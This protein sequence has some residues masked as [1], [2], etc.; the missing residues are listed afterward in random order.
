MAWKCLF[1]NEAA[2]TSSAAQAHF[3]ACRIGRPVPPT[4][5]VLDP[6]LR[7]I[8]VNYIGPQRP[9]PFEPRDHGV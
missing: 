4:K 9:V 1:C 6:R 8:P 7:W 5:P 3:D 2:E